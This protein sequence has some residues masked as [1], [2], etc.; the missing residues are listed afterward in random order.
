MNREVYQSSFQAN[1]SAIDF[2]HFHSTQTLSIF[3]ST[4]SFFVLQVTHI[5]F[6][7]KTSILAILSAVA[8]VSATDVMVIVADNTDGSLSQTLTLP[9][10][11]CRMF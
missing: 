2:I 8:L 10:G 1:F 3:Q 9:S 4:L 11:R 7:M 6:T 5:F